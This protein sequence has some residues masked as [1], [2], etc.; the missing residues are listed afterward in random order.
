[1]HY[2]WHLTDVHGPRLTGSPGLRAATIWA[3]AEVK[4]SSRP[5][6]RPLLQ[7]RCYVRPPLP[8]MRCQRQERRRG[9]RAGVADVHAS[10]LFGRSRL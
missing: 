9:D 10:F 5:D 6:D 2:A 3:E 8:H 1:M 4:R 7:Q